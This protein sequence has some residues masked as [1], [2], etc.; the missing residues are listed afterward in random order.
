MSMDEFLKPAEVA[1]R[2][3]MA[4]GTLAN[5]RSQEIGPKWYKVG[6]RVLYIAS[7]VEQYFRDGEHVPSVRA[8]VM[9]D[10]H[11]RP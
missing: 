1:A 7:E 4:T 5:W 2:Y 3:K 8:S 10:R 6:G 11:A 9:E